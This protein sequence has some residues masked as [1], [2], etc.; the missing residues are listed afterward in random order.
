MV[1]AFWNI[2]PSA[3]H[4]DG[5]CRIHTVSPQT[6]DKLYKL[7]LAFQQK[8]GVPILINTSFNNRGE[9]I[10]ETPEDAIKCFISTGI[11]CLVID[12]FVITKR[13]I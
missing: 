4:V 6:N 9:P 12:H 8:S 2:I 1:P 13:K 10:V 3:V 11:D 7:L 5:S